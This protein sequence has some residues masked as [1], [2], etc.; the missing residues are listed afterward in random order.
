[1]FIKAIKKIEE[2]MFPIYCA[3]DQADGLT[4]WIVVGT[5]FF[6]G[7]DGT[8][9]SVAH[10]FDGRTPQMRFHFLGHSP[11]HVLPNP[12][13][14]QELARDNQNDIFIGKID[15]KVKNPLILSNHV[16]QVGKT[17]CIAGYPL[18]TLITNPQGQL[19]LD[20]VRRYFQPSFVLDRAQGSVPF[21]TL[22]RTH[23]GF[24]I[25][26]AGLYG[27]SGGPVFDSKGK[28]IGIQGSVMSRTSTN[29]AKTIN[30]DNALIIKNELAVNLL[31]NEEI[32]INNNFFSDLRKRVYSLTSLFS[33]KRETAIV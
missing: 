21:G 32:K 19:V 24:L 29:G 13:E 8:F 20:G 12:I 5:G 10:L 11:N 1:M 28:V 26:D 33:K 17:I 30:I 7:K 27:M 23:N 25:R 31:K 16:P 4:R 3:E 2:G 14:I 15:F 22:V 9:L 6:I 18:V